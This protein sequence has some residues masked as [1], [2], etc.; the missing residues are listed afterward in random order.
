[1]AHREHIFTVVRQASVAVEDDCSQQPVEPVRTRGDVGCAVEVLDSQ[2]LGQFQ[3]KLSSLAVC[4]A[5]IRGVEHSTVAHFLLSDPAQNCSVVFAIFEVRPK[6]L[7]KA[8]QI[9][10][11]TSNSVKIDPT[12]EHFFRIQPSQFL[13]FQ[14]LQLQLGQAN[15]WVL[16]NLDQFGV[17]THIDMVVVARLNQL[18]DKV[19]RNVRFG[20]LHQLT[21]GGTG[22]LYPVRFFL[23]TWSSN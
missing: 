23:L 8:A 21:L 4:L 17:R 14:L 19:D 20:A 1:M 12:Q 18:V 15:L 16:S 9:S 6:I 22:D 13:G 11:C 2:L 7:D 5:G 10:R 3:D